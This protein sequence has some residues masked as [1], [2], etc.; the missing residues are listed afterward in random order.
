MQNYLPNVIQDTLVCNI[1]NKVFSKTLALVYMK[2][3]QNNRCRNITFA[4]L[5]LSFAIFWSNILDIEL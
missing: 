5:T 2:C 4:F 1:V 3:I